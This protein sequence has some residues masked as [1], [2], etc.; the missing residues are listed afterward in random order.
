MRNMKTY[1]SY[2]LE[3]NILAATAVIKVIDSILFSISSVAALQFSI[4]SEFDK[5]LTFQ[6][7][8]RLFFKLYNV[9][10]SHSFEI[11]FI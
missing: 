4:F 8:D 9:F 5:N 2:G 1:Q 3:S 6:L 11:C 7:Y 10:H